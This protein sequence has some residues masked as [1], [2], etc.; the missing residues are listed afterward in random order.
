MAPGANLASYWS[1]LNSDVELPTVLFATCTWES[2][3]PAVS[4]EILEC[5]SSFAPLAIAP[6][7]PLTARE[8]GLYFLKFFTELD[9]HSTDKITGRMVWFACSK[10]RELLKR[11]RLAGKFGLR[12]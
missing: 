8:A 12:C 6:Q 7:S 9:L 3:D 1:W 5:S 11:R 2:Y 10:A 4:K